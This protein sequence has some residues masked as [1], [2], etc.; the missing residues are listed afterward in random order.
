MSDVQRRI[1]A[2]AEAAARAALAEVADGARSLGHGLLDALEGAVFGEKG[3]AEAAIARFE[4]SDPRPAPVSSEASPRESAAAKAA[5]IQAK[6]AAL[7][8]AAAAPPGE[9]PPGKKTL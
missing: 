6:L 3:G 4:G 2:A 8:A 7:K 5:R 9:S 1:E